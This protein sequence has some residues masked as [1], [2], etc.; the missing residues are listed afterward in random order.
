MI[1][2]P[3]IVF[4]NV[5]YARSVQFY[6]RTAG[7]ERHIGLADDGVSDFVMPVI[8]RWCC[9]SLSLHSGRLLDRPKAFE[10]ALPLFQMFF[11][12]F[13]VVECIHR[14]ERGKKFRGRSRIIIYF[15]CL[16]RSQQD[17]ISVRV[18]TQSFASIP[19]IDEVMMYDRLLVPFHCRVI[20]IIQR[21]GKRKHQQH[22]A[23][24]H[25]RT[26]QL[27]LQKWLPNIRLVIIK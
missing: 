21:D 9:C 16:G 23:D 5:W 11:F 12:S 26:C 7:Y 27:C 6:L 15:T 13:D 17:K 20:C 10:V 25:P 19:S 22:E 1:G 8:N 2:N 24:I 4:P 14:N 3:R 18:R